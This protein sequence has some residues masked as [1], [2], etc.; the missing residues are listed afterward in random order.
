LRPGVFSREATFRWA[1]VVFPP[2]LW[3]LLYCPAVRPPRK[4]IRLPAI[5]YGGRGIHFLT[6][7]CEF[8]RRPFLK[9][10]FAH[11]II[12]DLRKYAEQKQFAVHAYCVMPN[13]LHMLAEG[14]DHSCDLLSFL[15]IFKQVTAYKYKSRT[16]KRLWQKKFYD[17]ILRPSDSQDAVAWYIWLNP[18]RANLCADFRDYFC[19]GSFTMAWPKQ[20]PENGTWIPAW[21][22]NR[23][24]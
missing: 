8:K 10:E 5:N 22:Q 6:L 19:S 1:A 24:T 17:H 2:N 16:G 3:H 13:H 12:D 21:K 20:K 15:K 11:E 9:T 18:V 23:P 7:C 14:R 4:N